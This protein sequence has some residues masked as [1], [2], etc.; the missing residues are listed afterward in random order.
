MLEP[1]GL[2]KTPSIGHVLY[3]VK[4]NKKLPVRYHSVKLPDGCTKWSP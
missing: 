4:D 3:V 1:D 2:V